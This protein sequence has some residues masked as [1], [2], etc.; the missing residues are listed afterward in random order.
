MVAWNA[1]TEADLLLLRDGREV[2]VQL[3]ARLNG[4]AVNAGGV[5]KQIKLQ[6]VATFLR[7]RAQ[8]AVGNDDRGFAVK[9]DYI[10]DRFCVPTAQMLD[11]SISA[12]I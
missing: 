7:S 3:K 2:I 5:G 8:K 9:F 1:R 4:E 10:L 12:L 6:G 11:D